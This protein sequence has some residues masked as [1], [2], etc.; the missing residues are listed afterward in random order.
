MTDAQPKRRNRRPVVVPDLNALPDHA[1]L[2]RNQ[3]AQLTSFSLPT[4]K[5]WAKLGRGPKLIRVEGRPRYPAGP[6]RQWAA[7]Q[8][9]S[10]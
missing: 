1:L 5:V 8:A 10:Q 7:G 4:L 3:V 2:T 6:L 9:P